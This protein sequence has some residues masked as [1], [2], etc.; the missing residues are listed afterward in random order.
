MMA[1]DLKGGTTINIKDFAEKF[2]RAEDEAWMQGKFDSL[3]AL[4]HPDI[5]LNF[6]PPFTTVGREAQQRQILD[7]RAAFPGLRVDWKYLAGDGGLFALSFKMNGNYT[8]QLP[9]FSPP[10]GQPVSVDGLFLFRVGNGV[11][12]EAWSRSVMKG[13]SLP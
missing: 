7:H 5:V 8:G 6:T 3:F 12:V 4:E 13:L 2:I 9:G 10:Q 11:I 1:T